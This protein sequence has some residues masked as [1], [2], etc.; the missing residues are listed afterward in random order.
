MSPQWYSHQDQGGLGGQ[1]YCRPGCTLDNMATMTADSTATLQ[2]VR[3]LNA[4]T[5]EVL[6]EPIHPWLE[7]VTLFVLKKWTW[8]HGQATFPGAHTLFHLHF[9]MAQQPVDDFDCLGSLTTG[10]ALDIS[11]VL[12]HPQKP[13]IRTRKSIA[14]AIVHHRPKR[15]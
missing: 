6:Y 9:S 5:G 1:D 12:K 2:R 11:C 14:D 15:L 3:V 7:R 13:G 8:N 4:L 10:P